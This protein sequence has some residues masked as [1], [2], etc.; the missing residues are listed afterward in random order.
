MLNFY[1]VIIFVGKGMIMGILESLGIAWKPQEGV[2]YKSF[3][4]GREKSVG[5]KV[6]VTLSYREQQVTIIISGRA[7]NGTFSIRNG[8][9]VIRMVGENRTKTEFFTQIDNVEFKKKVKSSIET[10]RNQYGMTFRYPAKYVTYT[11]TVLDTDK[12]RKAA[13]KPD[14]VRRRGT[15]IIDTSKGILVVSGK[16]KLFILPGGGAERGESRTSAVARE[17]KEE[18]GL[19]VTDVKYLF[20]HHDAPDRKIRNLHKIFLVK[21]EGHVRPDGHEV[22][23]VAYW[24]PGSEVNISNTTKL[25]IQKYIDEYK[26]KD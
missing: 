22:K 9:C 1:K 26:E 6:Y 14:I 13:P 5:Q 12:L 3:V 2:V 19:K 7:V 16:R 18:T 21:T 11:I 8:I 15:A 10:G 20:T 24:K 4:K 17:V 23:H 25:L